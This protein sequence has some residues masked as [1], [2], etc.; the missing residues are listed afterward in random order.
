M[1]IP[2]VLAADPSAAPDHGQ[3]IVDALNAAAAV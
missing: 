2:A 3:R 1:A